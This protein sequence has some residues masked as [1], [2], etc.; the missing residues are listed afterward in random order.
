MSST[1]MVILPRRSFWVIQSK[2]KTSNRICAL[3]ASVVKLKAS[4]AHTGLRSF[5]TI[6][7]CS[8]SSPTV[9]TTNGSEAS[10]SI[11]ASLP[12]VF[13]RSWAESTFTVRTLPAPASAEDL[14]AL[15]SNSN[16]WRSFS[17]VLSARSMRRLSCCSSRTL[18]SIS[19][20]PS[21]R[22]SLRVSHLPISIPRMSTS[23][24]PSMSSK[25]SQSRS[26]TSSRRV[27]SAS[28]KGNENSFE[29]Q[30]GFKSLS[31]VAVQNLLLPTE[32]MA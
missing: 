28:P 7:V 16:S 31:T 23:T 13:A 3:G 22:L 30:A 19:P 20:F 24:L 12:S 9:T 14:A 10:P 17:P 25:V 8:F 6:L 32:T 11:F 2:S 1:L 27:L 15:S 26:K 5:H 21:P 4:P 18:N 29:F